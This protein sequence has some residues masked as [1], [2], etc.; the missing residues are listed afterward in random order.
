MRQEWDYFVVDIDRVNLYREDDAE[1]FETIGIDELLAKA[2]YKRNINQ[3]EV[4]A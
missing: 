1:P 3:V 4:T 2:G